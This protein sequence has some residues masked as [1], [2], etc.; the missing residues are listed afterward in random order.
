MR[1]KYYLVPADII[2][3]NFPDDIEEKEF[4]DKIAPMQI[5][6]ADLSGLKE[7]SREKGSI[8]IVKQQTII[9]DEKTDDYILGF[10]RI[11]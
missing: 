3:S 9:E 7:M 6:E 2:E 11:I 4:N 8:I 5:S 10:E 1:N